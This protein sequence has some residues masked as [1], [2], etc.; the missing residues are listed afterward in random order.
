[1]YY[2]QVYT[3]SN[4]VKMTRHIFL[5]LYFSLLFSFNELSHQ[6]IGLLL[7]L[8]CLQCF[9]R[10][11]KLSVFPFVPVPVGAQ[12]WPA[13]SSLIVSPASLPTGAGCDRPLPGVKGTRN[14]SCQETR[15]PQ[16]PRKFGKKNPKQ[17][18]FKI[19]FLLGAPACWG[20]LAL[21]RQTAGKAASQ[22]AYPPASQALYHQHGLR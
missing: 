22:A 10:F 12:R 17:A 6:R 9:M 15:K 13:A 7:L 1:M 19:S 14:Q 20:A 16:R 11:L 3:I 8:L 21:L 2:S 4:T 5:F 18:I